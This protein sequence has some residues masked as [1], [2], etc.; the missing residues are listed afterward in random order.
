MS[1]NPS[2]GWARHIRYYGDNR[3][4][5]RDPACCR[6]NNAILEAFSLHTS[7]SRD[8]RPLEALNYL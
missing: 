8:E 5:G 3:T 1:S 6:G 4:A 2:H 7:V